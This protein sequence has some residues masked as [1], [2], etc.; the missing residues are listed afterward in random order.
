MIGQATARRIQR[1]FEKTEPD[2]QGFL[3][4]DGVM[5]GVG[6]VK[7]DSE[8]IL[9]LAATDVVD[10]LFGGLDLPEGTAEAHQAVDHDDA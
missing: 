9:G 10:P 3:P 7:D 6:L 2:L 4:T 8:D 5:V 1:K